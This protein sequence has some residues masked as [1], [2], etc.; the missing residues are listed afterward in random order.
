MLART[1]LAQLEEEAKAR[2]QK[3]HRETHAKYAREQKEFNL[4]ETK[5]SLERLRT[6]REAELMWVSHFVAAFSSASAAFDLRTPF[7]STTILI[8]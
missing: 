6:E 4:H 7:T 1:S 3:L 2:R 8:N 5:S